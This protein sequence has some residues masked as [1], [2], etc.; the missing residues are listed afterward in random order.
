MYGV[1]KCKNRIK[2][3]MKTK[4]FSGDQKGRTM[5]LLI[6]PKQTTSVF[7]VALGLTCFGLLRAV[8]AV[9]PAPDGGY[10]GMNT[11]EGDN[12]LLN[13]TTGTNNTA[14]GRS[15]LKSITTGSDN[16]AVGASTLLH[17]TADLNTA[18]GFEALTS[19]TTG[20]ENTA[21]GYS[22]LSFNRTGTDNTANGWEALFSNT[23]GGANTANGA[24]ALGS[25]TTGSQNTANGVDALASNTTSSNNTATGF[26]AL[27]SNTT[28]DLNTAN[29]A[30]ALSANTGGAE[31][32]ANGASALALNT[33]GSLN[34]AN[35]TVAL[36]SNT[37]GSGNTATGVAA[38]TN[39]ATGSNNTTDGWEA[40]SNN[41]TGSF[42]IA[43][44]T[45]AGSNLT[46]GSYNID[47]GSVGA[48][49]ESNTMRI[50]TVHQTS[51]FITGIYGATAT[52]GIPV[53]INSNNKLGTTTSS[54]RFKEDIKPM[55]SASE[56]ILGLKPVTFRY[57]K[58]IDP[59]GTSQFGL[60]AEDVEKVDPDLIVRDKEGKPY[61]VR[62]DQVNAM[63]LNEFLKEH[64]T[65]QE[66]KKEIETLT[67]TVKEQA[68]QIQKVSTEL[69]LSEPTS[70][71]VLNSQ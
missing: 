24:A 52:N 36:R 19:N 45:S 70:K 15:S 60:V 49:G 31:N 39:N 67:A 46:T 9:T 11:A 35:G 27:A 29:G 5:N 61:S 57:K 66:L 69:E 13:L 22:A 14:I 40:L 34:T 20:S 50:G 7:L 25:N 38:L 2:S 18:V 48:M 12:A 53:L 16:T 10:P 3:P 47:I 55:D 64:R 6:Q 65:V 21:T 30:E 42:N 8:Q 37:I 41:T 51:T 59:A 1:A 68:A 23:T 26:S 58:E 17:N 56:A 71:T 62:Y 33:T 32:T 28:G 44:G 54:K 63:L 43:I 4:Q